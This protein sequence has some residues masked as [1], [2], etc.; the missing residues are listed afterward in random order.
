MKTGQYWQAAQ[1]RKVAKLQSAELSTVEAL[2]AS[3]KL[4]LLAQSNSH[5]FPSKFTN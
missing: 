2:F 3:T 1:R 5:F 4:E